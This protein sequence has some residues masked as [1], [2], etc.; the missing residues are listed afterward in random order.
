MIAKKKG[1]FDVI[2]HLSSPVSLSFN[3]N[4]V[5]NIFSKYLHFDEWQSGIIIDDELH[6]VSMGHVGWQLPLDSN[7]M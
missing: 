6:R 5:K 7:F 4:D 1:N 3:V 2:F